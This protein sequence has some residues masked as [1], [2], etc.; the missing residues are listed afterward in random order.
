MRDKRFLFPGEIFMQIMVESEIISISNYGRIYK[1]DN[2]GIYFGSLTE[3]G[4]RRITIGKSYYYVHRLVATTFISRPEHLKDIPYEE[5]EV[6]HKDGNKSNNRVDN[7]EWCTNRENVQHT[8]DKM[9]HKNIRPIIQYDL[10]GNRIN[11]FRSIAE[12]SRSINVHRNSSIRDCC[13]GRIRIAHGYVWRYQDEPF[14]LIENPKHTPVIQFDCEGKFI[15]HYNSITEAKRITGVENI[16]YCC[17]GRYK[18]AGGA[19]A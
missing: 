8:Y 3:Q 15:A 12:A 16:S 11:V 9:N 18:T 10:N 7:L 6:N 2:W 1:D 19:I 13:K 5:L 4:Y 17:S 14:S